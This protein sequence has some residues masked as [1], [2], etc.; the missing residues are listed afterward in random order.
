VCNNHE[1]VIVVLTNSDYRTHYTRLLKE[2]TVDI[3]I[4]NEIVEYMKN[5]TKKKK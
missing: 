2:F 3:V 1:N 4:R 5:K